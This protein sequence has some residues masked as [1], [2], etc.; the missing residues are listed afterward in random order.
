MFCPACGVKTTDDAR[1]CPECGAVI[2]H[3][4]YNWE[5]LQARAVEE[6]SFKKRQKIIAIIIV[7]IVLA[8]VVPSAIALEYGNTAYVCI[9]VHST[10]VTEDVDV[11]FII[12]GDVVMTYQGLSPGEYCWNTKWFKVHFRLLDE[13]KLITVK[14]ISTGGLL[15]TQQDSKDL[16]V[17]NNEH[18]YVDLYV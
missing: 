9:R 11:Q 18:Y 16:I 5:Y 8:T 6:R 14:A 3:E 10:H 4:P 12:D 7:V 1:F 17:F 15:G 13:S 2:R